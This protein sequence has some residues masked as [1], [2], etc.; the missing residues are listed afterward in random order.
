M[1]RPLTQ[2]AGY[3]YR[4]AMPVHRR[5]EPAPCDRPTAEPGAILITSTGTYQ[6]TEAG[7]TVPR[8]RADA[9]TVCEETCDPEVLGARMPSWCAGVLLGAAVC[10]P[11]LYFLGAF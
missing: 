10:G 1:T 11:V 9:V 3:S 6:V 5:T 7:N 4:D 2:P 8:S